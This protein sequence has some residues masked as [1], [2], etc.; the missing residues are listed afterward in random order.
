M[1]ALPIDQPRCKSSGDL[2]CAKGCSGRIYICLAARLSPGA[3][4]LVFAGWDA[5]AVPGFHA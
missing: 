2:G 3:K 1:L 4:V 5:A